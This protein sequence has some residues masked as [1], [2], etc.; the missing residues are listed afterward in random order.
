MG[1][2]VF[3]FSLPRTFA[4]P[5]YGR[6]SAPTPSTQAEATNSRALLLPSFIFLLLKKIRSELCA[7]HSIAIIFPTLPTSC[8]L[9]LSLGLL[10]ISKAFASTCL[11]NRLIKEGWSNLIPSSSSIPPTYLLYFRAPWSRIRTSSLRCSMPN[12]LAIFSSVFLV[13]GRP[14]TWEVAHSLFQSEVSA[15]I[16]PRL[17]VSIVSSKIPSTPR[18]TSFSCLVAVLFSPA[19]GS[20]SRAR[21]RVM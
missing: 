14:V 13:Y 18:S 21:L 4:K 2:L 7:R 3:H 8:L 15:T 11:S 16:S 12:L 10:F 17:P 6:R 20:L 19:L 1:G 5:S 9:C